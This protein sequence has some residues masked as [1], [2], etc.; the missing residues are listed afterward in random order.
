MT[1]V[2]CHGDLVAMRI[3]DDWFVCSGC[4]H[5][6]WPVADTFLIDPDGLPSEHGNENENPEEDGRQEA[7]FEPGR[8]SEA[9]GV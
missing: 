3:V 9:G 8:G 2:Y 1:R 6:L 4:G 5:D 7:R